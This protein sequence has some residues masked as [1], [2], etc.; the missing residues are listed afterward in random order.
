MAEH[1]KNNPCVIGWQ[2]DNE[3]G[4]SHE[5]LCMCENCRNAFG[6]WLQE[7]YGNIETLN[8]AWGT[9]FWSQTYDDFEPVSYTHLDVYKRQIQMNVLHFWCRCCF[10]PVL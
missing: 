4:N 7:K 3:L 5:D 9:V 2:I 6:K 8:E 1:F 10:F